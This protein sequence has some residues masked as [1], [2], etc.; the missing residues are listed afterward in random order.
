[1]FHIRPALVLF[2]MLSLITGVLY[3]LAITA[4]AQVAFPN[5]ANGS[6]IASAAAGD[7]T[8]RG[9]SLIGQDF[10]SGDSRDA[11]RWFWG[12]PS[13][14]SP[15]PYI[16]FNLGTGTGSSGS[17]LAPTNPALFAN[18]R[19]RIDALNAADTAVGLDRAASDA[20][21]P[22]DLV[23]SSASGLDPHISPAAAEYQVPRVAK[24]R[25]TTEDAVRALVELH[26]SGRT[27]S[28]LG[29]PVVNVLELNLALDQLNK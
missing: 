17:N 22:I 25:A 18:I 29:E 9:S 26:T 16:A 8:F 28:L 1:M 20:R 5:Q 4:I 23:T 27:L 12:R 15:L 24:A 2:A 3:P 11:A 10:S 7:S 21:I 14:T 19:S 13:A 6:M